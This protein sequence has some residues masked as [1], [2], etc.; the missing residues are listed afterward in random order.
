MTT[1]RVGFHA[2]QAFKDHSKMQIVLDKG[3]GLELSNFGRLLK[4]S[5]EW[6]MNPD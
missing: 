4:M 3:L 6:V 5:Q 1:C 2:I